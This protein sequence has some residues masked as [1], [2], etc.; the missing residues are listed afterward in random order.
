[1]EKVPRLSRTQKW[2]PGCYSVDN[3]TQTDIRNKKYIINS[4]S[5]INNIN[6][7]QLFPCI[8]LLADLWSIIFLEMFIYT[9][10]TYK[11]MNICLI[12]PK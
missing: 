6:E 4:A 7:I 5:E 10:L 1:M 12:D 8:K 9:L 3:I 11:Y 2:F